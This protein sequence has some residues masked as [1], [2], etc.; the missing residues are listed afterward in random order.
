MPKHGFYEEK[1]K[2]DLATL[3][4]RIAA[5]EAKTKS[6]TAGSTSSDGCMFPIGTILMMCPD[7]AAGESNIYPSTMTR[8][9]GGTWEYIGAGRTVV[10]CAPGDINGGEYFNSKAQHPYDNFA[11][12]HKMYGRVGYAGF[13]KT[14]FHRWLDGIN[15]PRHRH[16]ITVS[17]HTHSID[18]KHYI[19]YNGDDFPASAENN[20]IF[21]NET[22][23]GSQTRAYIKT[24]GT[25]GASR[26]ELESSNEV[27]S[28]WGPMLAGDFAYQKDGKWEASSSMQSGYT[29]PTASC[30]TAYGKGEKE[31]EPVSIAQPFITTYMFRRKA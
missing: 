10:S 13:W 28:V 26:G 15:L 1:H 11:N 24:D 20:Y 5:L 9:F 18:H 14:E 25:A 7:L 23:S 31:V 27:S 8:L 3:E 22:R 6:F 2:Y 21:N 17:G 30:S 16:T 12:P 29:A 19:E 4:D